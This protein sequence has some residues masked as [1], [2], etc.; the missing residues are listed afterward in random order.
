MFRDPGRL[1]SRKA[2]IATIPAQCSP[3]MQ[4]SLHCVVSVPGASTDRLEEPP[5]SHPNLA[6]PLLGVQAL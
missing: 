4:P 5:L 2:G 6:L 1:M 3:A